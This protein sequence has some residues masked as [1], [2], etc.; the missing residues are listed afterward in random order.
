MYD[1]TEDAEWVAHKLPCKKCGSSNNVSVN[2]KGWAKCFGASCKANYKHEDFTDLDTA[3]DTYT[4]QTNTNT[5]SSVFI[6]AA[7]DYRDLPER[8]LTQATTKAFK[9]GCGYYNNTPCTIF[10][11]YRDGEL[12]AQKLRAGDSSGGF[13]MK[14]GSKSK[15]VILGDSKY[16][17]NNLFGSSKW[18]QGGN[19]IIITEGE[20]DCMAMSQVQD[21]KYPVVSIPSGAGSAKKSLGNCKDWLQDNFKEIILMFDND[22]AGQAAIEEVIPVFDDPKRVKI[23]RL[24]YNDANEMLLKGEAKALTSSIFNASIYRPQGLV[25]IDDI[26]HLIGYTPEMGNAYPWDSLTKWVYGLGRP[27]LNVWG[28]GTGMGKT[29][30]FKTIAANIIKTYKEK[31]GIIFLEE[32]PQETATYI[33]GAYAGMDFNSP[34]TKFKK[35][36]LDDA[37]DAIKDHVIL[38]RIDAMNDWATVKSK[39]RHMIVVDE[40]KYIFLDHITKFSDNAQAGNENKVIEEVCSNLSDMVMELNANINVICHLRKTGINQVPFEEGGEISLDDFKGSGAIKQYAWNAF[41]ISRN[42]K[43]KRE[44]LKHVSKVTLEKSRKAGKNEGSYAYIKF[45]A[46]TGCLT[47]L[48]KEYI[49][50]ILEESNVKVANGFRDETL[51]RKSSQEF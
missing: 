18:K 36:D 10:P 33:A 40:C 45:N 3:K 7:G 35:S 5:S 19:K 49:D 15:Y 13:P 16:L 23:A 31:V 30:F 38:N 44:E 51:P 25:T 12:V 42:K 46:E 20:F 37:L 11:Y 39:I 32:T 9:V 43:E 17:M 48:D 27:E 8:G 34:D 28:A 24:P 1:D 41:S 4:M 26:R 2:S 14:D 21:H 22:K 50:S 6:E 29:L 47:E